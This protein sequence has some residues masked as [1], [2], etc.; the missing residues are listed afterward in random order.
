MI[1][2]ERQELILSYLKENRF[3]TIKELSKIVWASES[4]VR[5]DLRVLEQKGFVTQIYGGV[6][7][8]DFAGTV[9]PIELRDSYNSTVKDILAK[10]A[11]KHIFDGATIFM[12]GSSTVKRIMQYLSPFTNLKI[13]TNNQLIFSECTNTGIKL[14][15]TGGLYNRQSNIFSGS[16]AESYIDSVNADILFFSSQ[17]MSE[18]GEISDVSEEETSLRKKMLSRAKKKIF[19]CDSSKLG[20]KKTFTLCTKDDVDVIICDKKLPWE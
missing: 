11:S 1:I 16:A 13:I 15:C 19:L 12:D 17:A 9:V 5:R 20:L 7:L 14:Y 10:K 4:S 3:A 8:S 6:T 18:E 2:Y